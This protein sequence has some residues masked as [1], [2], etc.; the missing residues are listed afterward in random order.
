MG[1]SDDNA[2][3]ADEHLLDRCPFCDYSLQGLPV[4]HT[5]P[6]CGQPFDRRW[7]LFSPSRRVDVWAILGLIVLGVIA[8]SAVVEAINGEWFDI[9]E[10]VLNCMVEAFVVYV[11]FRFP[12][13]F[14]AVGP[15]GLVLGK[16][17][18]W[19]ASRFEQARYNWNEVAE[20]RVRGDTGR[21]VVDV[22]GGQ[23]AAFGWLDGLLLGSGRLDAC[24]T[25]INAMA[26][27][28]DEQTAGGGSKVQSDG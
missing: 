14:V 5:C 11:V 20:A 21:L 4:E 2:T 28:A 19:Q 9:T 7:Q 24:K 23:V 8:V 3:A 26:R 18:R 25:A 12:T 16:R 22:D 27:H 13:R 17:Y 10:A 15:T 1:T 6:E